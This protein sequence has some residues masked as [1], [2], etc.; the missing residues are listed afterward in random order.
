MK[1]DLDMDVVI[2][3][4]Q[5]TAVDAL[6]AADVGMAGADNEACESNDLS[7]TEGLAAA[8][9]NV[10]EQIAL[11][12]ARQM[13]TVSAGQFLNREFIDL[14][15]KPD[16]VTYANGLRLTGGC[17]EVVFSGVLKVVRHPDGAA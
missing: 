12:R 4:A 15:L 6:A 8:E 16:H 10:L 13:K 17:P 2:G 3:T 9:V 5:L 14:L 1:G 11:A 7:F